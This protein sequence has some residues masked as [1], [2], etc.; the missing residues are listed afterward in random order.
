MQD[1]KDKSTI[2]IFTGAR[3]VGRPRVHQSNAM[4]QRLY[5]QRKKGKTSC[6]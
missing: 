5:R 3:P 6:Q 1:K 4:K 2:D